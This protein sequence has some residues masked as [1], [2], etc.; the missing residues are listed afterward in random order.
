MLLKGFLDNK[1]LARFIK[2]LPIFF[3]L[4]SGLTVRYLFYRSIDGPILISDSPTYIDGAMSLY[5][6]LTFNE[7]RPPVYPLMLMILGVTYFWENLGGA[8][9]ILQII[10]SIVCI[11]YIYKLV[12]VMFH[13]NSLSFLAALVVSMSFSIYNWDFMVLT[14][15]ISIMLVTLISYLLVM[16]IKY[17]KPLHM[18]VLLILLFT[19][20]FTK[21]F[22]L[23]LPVLI[24]F[25]IGLDM[26][27]IKY[28]YHKPVDIKP[29]K[30]FIL[31]L[32]TIYLSVFIYS[33]VNY[34]ENLYFGFSS[35]G[36]VNTFGKV[37]QYGMEEYGSNKELVKDIKTAMRN[38]KQEYIVNASF[39]E[40][41]HFVGTYGWNKNH[42]REVS[43][44][45]KEII[46]KHPIEYISRSLKL[47][48]E[49]FFFNSPFKDYI[50]LGAITKANHPE[51]VM[52]S[53]KNL[54]QKFE[55]LY[56]LLF[57]CLFD[58]IYLLIFRKKERLQKDGFI[59]FALL[60]IILY[61][62]FI[63]AFL[64]YGD[65]SRL[66]APSY[67]LTYIIICIYI[68]RLSASIMQLASNSARYLLQI[69]KKACR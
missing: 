26:F 66:L 8:I 40:P 36:N 17:K 29:F 38:E 30:T 6:H 65:Y 49:L 69:R 50:A 2:L 63:S 22:F 45:S 37:L 14:E 57:L 53:I 28:I 60:S 21:P 4:I 58:M 20:I 25:L 33:A 56:I 48:G 68:Y 5:Y 59:T 35:V 62:Y 42:Y 61:H 15:S 52:L 7:Y 27:F 34:A 24:L 43:K 10:L 9:V 23:L 16:Y 11:V 31:G 12:D 1:T 47:T 54:T 13:K 44:F 32:C 18:K 39:L 55:T 67:T 19:S 3:V 41:W 51:P 64:S 46:M